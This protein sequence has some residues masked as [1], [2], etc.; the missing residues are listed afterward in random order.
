MPYAIDTHC[1]LDFIPKEERKRVIDRAI[2]ANVQKMITVACNLEQVEECILLA[3]QYDFIWTTV[4]IHP[5]DLTD[6][7][8]R[9]L[10]KVYET[11]KNTKKVVAIGEIG[12][13][14]YHDR[15][16][17]EDQI[18]FLTGQL[19][20]ANQLKKPAILHSRAGKFAGENS[21]VFPDMLKVLKD[22]QTTNAVMHCFSGSYEE[23]LQFLNLGLMIS[24]TG[25]VTYERNEELRRIIKEMPIDRI[26][27]ETDAPFL[28]PKKHKGQKNE[29][30]FVME[31][32]KT[33]AE[34]RGLEM[35][36][37]LEITSR[38]AEHFFRI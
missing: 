38:N 29:P 23:A 3:D 33:I 1:H 32:A 19:D 7:L 15:F 31:V 8:E 18:D 34:V 36:E 16:P 35:D 27:I 4:G 24:F 12:L 9:D 22:T 17:H 37:V 10:K 28:P 13:D 20:I 26:M 21:N 5:T 6:N 14:Y 11:A 30:A 25:I 2:K